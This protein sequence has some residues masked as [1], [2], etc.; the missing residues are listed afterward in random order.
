ME[1][2]L[3]QREK[4]KA[5][6]DAH[7]VEINFE[8]YTPLLSWF[9]AVI[10]TPRDQNC[11]LYAFS[12]KDALHTGA[13]TQGIG[14]FSDLSRLSPY[15]FNVLIHKET[16]KKK[17]IKSGDKIV[18]E[19]D[20]GHK[21]SGIVHTIEGIHPQCLAFMSGSGKW[22]RGAPLARGKGANLNTLQEL[23][24]E[25]CCPITLNLETAARAKVYTDRS[26]RKK[27]IQE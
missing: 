4:M 11:D 10:D 24:L 8:Q 22:A 12:F 9:P 1:F 26:K 17:N 6:C 14:I 16:A 27:G 7:D 5:I 23:D 13:M 15:V 25:H 21:T 3:D 18:I 19:N 20:Y 2:I